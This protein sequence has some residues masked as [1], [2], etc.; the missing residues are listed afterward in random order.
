LGLIAL[1]PTAREEARS[2]PCGKPAGRRPAVL[3]PINNPFEKPPFSNSAAKS[4]SNRYAVG[5]TKLLDQAIEK[6]YALPAEM[7]D[8]AARMLLVYA[9]DDGP[10][11]ELTQVEEADLIEALAEM[12]RGETASEAEVSSALSKYRL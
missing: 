11:I 5:M 10:M 9:G 1:D 8:Q 2:L 12:R 6:V 3:G 4:A 7:Q